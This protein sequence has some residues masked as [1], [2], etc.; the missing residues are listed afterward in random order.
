MKRYLFAALMAT[1]LVGF[2][3][4]SK[5]EDKNVAEEGVGTY[6]VK[7][8]YFFEQDKKLYNSGMEPETET[9]TVSLDGE[10]LKVEIDGDVLKL[11]KIREASNGF[12]FDVE[13]V[14]FTDEGESFTL[15][16]YNGFVLGED[17]AYAGAY[18]SATKKLEF[19]YEMSR[20]KFYDIFVDEM[21]SDEEWVKS[22]L[23]E[24]GY[25]NTD[26][27]KAYALSYAKENYGEYRFVLDFE[28]T[29]K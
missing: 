1:V 27:I 8:T 29:K 15:T 26:E 18:I 17:V 2:A 11:V 3:S 23:E 25:A 6:D 16:G 13:D 24:K 14:T 21:M 5:D 12:T 19:Y 9:A 10:N 7:I 22:C 4:C 20:D 28:C